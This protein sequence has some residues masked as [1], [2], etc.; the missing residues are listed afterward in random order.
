[1]FFDVTKYVLNFKAV[2]FLAAEQDFFLK[3]VP[4]IH[5]E[6]LKNPRGLKEILILIPFTFS[7]EIKNDLEYFSD[8]FTNVSFGETPSVVWHTVL[9]SNALI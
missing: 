8:I 7:A 5:F 2:T 3:G 6:H 9:F 1:M 4:N